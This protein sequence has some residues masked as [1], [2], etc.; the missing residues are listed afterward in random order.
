MALRGLPRDISNADAILP[1]LSM[2]LCTYLFSS[3]CWSRE[4][5]GP[6]F[7]ESLRFAR[8]FPPKLKANILVGSALIW[9]GTPTLLPFSPLLSSN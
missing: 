1:I 5:E 6:A 9:D 3:L 4:G 8:V 7:A 2:S